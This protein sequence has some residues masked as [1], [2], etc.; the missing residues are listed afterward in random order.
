M[1]PRNKTLMDFHYIVTQ[2]IPP[3]ARLAPNLPEIP[4]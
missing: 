3:I 4:S 1:L 2:L